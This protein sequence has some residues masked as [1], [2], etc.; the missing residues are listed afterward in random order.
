MK[1]LSVV[2]I[3]IVALY[4]SSLA[5]AQLALPDFP[6]HGHVITVNPDSSTQTVERSSGETS[7]GDIVIV[8]QLDKK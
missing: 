7:L 4:T 2:V 6:Q 8:K 5:F 3:L 1:R